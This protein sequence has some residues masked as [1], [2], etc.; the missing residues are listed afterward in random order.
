MNANVASAAQGNLGAVQGAIMSE[1]KQEAREI[2][3]QAHAKADD[4]R[5]RADDETQKQVEGILSRAKEQAER[6]REQAAAQARL[7]AQHLK[8]RRR[9]QLLDKAFEMAQ[10]R[11]DECLERDDY[12][13]LVTRVV[14]EAVT[15]LGS[16]E[17]ALLIQ[18]D[19][20][21]QTILEESLDNLQKDVEVLLE[22]GDPLQS[23]HG[24]IVETQDGHRRYDNRL[25]TRLARLKGELRAPVY[26]ILKGETAGE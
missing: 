6:R 21:A 11:L 12:P 26:H 13:D 15:R 5:S 14:R 3:E 17:Q 24:I 25:E 8:L 2:I 23:G 22:L 7:E 4:Y 16:T 20:K 10:S 18:A 9:E 19:E 1:V